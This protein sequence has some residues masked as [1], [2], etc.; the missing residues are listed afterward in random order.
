[1]T[2][3]ITEVTDAENT[4]AERYGDFEQVNGATVNAALDEV[5]AKDKEIAELKACLRL[6]QDARFNWGGM[7]IKDGQFIVDV[8]DILDAD[9]SQSLAAHDAAIWNEAGDLCG[10]MY[11]GAGSAHSI[12]A[13]EDCTKLLRQK[14]KEV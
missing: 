11:G 4:H 6:L 7:A 2:D 3:D 12:L 5:D 13:V 14:A 1:M 10:T 9:P 8:V